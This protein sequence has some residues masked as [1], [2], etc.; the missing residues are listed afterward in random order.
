MLARESHGPRAILNAL[1]RLANGC[2]SECESLR[3]DLAIAETQL[4]DY[5]A[6]VGK[7]FAFAAYLSE[8][9]ALRDQLKVVL[10]ST[11][12]QA[13]IEKGP[14]ASELAERIKAI[15][16]A[17][18]VEATPQRIRQKHASAEEPVTARIRRRQEAL[19]SPTIDADNAS[20]TRVSLRLAS[21]PSS[22]SELRTFH[23]PRAIPAVTH[24][25]QSL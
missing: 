14:N 17:H 22:S 23:D 16:A 10:S 11:A 7:P 19:P 5:Q 20:E 15:K 18:T 3:Q 13:D 25:H 24:I 2:H 12:H 1:E 21:V 4:R 8:L 6:R 9:T